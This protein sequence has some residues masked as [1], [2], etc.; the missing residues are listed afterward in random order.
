MASVLPAT[1]DLNAVFCMTWDEETNYLKRGYICGLNGWYDNKSGI[2]RFPED[3]LRSLTPLYHYE[4][5]SEVRITTGAI[6]G[7][8]FLI[9]DGVLI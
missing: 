1:R 7:Y 5:S 9:V 4:P 6:Q 3:E 8:S 2:E